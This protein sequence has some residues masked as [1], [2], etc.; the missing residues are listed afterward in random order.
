[1][2]HIK[3]FWITESSQTIEWHNSNVDIGSLDNSKNVN[4]SYTM[5]KQDEINDVEKGNGN[6]SQWRNGFDMEVGQCE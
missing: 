6:I 1:M 5:A 2:Q 4:L 3:Y